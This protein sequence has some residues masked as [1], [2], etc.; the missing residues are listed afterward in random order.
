MCDV[1]LELVQQDKQLMNLQQAVDALETE[2][3]LLISVVCQT[4]FTNCD[5]N[6]MY[7]LFYFL[8]K[9]KHSSVINE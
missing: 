3:E 6:A 4:D 9:E 1:L 8:C 7:Q 5:G 2:Q